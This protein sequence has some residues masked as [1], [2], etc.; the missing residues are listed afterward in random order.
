MGKKFS[1]EYGQKLFDNKIKLATN[2][3]KAALN[4]Q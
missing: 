4:R 3:S 2:D 1:C